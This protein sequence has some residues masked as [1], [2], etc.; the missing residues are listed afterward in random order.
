MYLSDIEILGFK[1]FAQK[2]N[3]K[4]TTGMTAIV[5]PNGCG[6]TNVVD[7][8]RWV[9]GEQKASTLRSDK[10]Y[11]VIFN[12][13][14]NRRPLGLAEVSLII[15]N[16]RKILPTEYSHVKIT[17]RLFRSSESQYLLNGVECRLRDINDLFM[18]TGMGPDAYSV[19]ELKMIETILSSKADERRRL[20][21]E[22]AGVTKYKARRKEAERKLEAVQGDL[23]RIQDIVIE[24][25]KTVRS[26]SR[27]AAKSKLAAE[28]KR[29]YDRIEKMILLLEYAALREQ[30]SPL[31]I[32]LAEQRTL[33][34]QL[35]NDVNEQ[36][37]ALGER[38]QAQNAVQSRFEDAENELAAA[39]TTVG[40]ASRELAVSNERRLALE[41]SQ[42]RLLRESEELAATLESTS[43]RLGEAQTEREIAAAELASTEGDYARSKALQDEAAAVVQSERNRTR[44]ANEAVRSAMSRIAAVRAEA[45]RT[46]ASINA[47]RRRIDET[48]RA[49]QQAEERLLGVQRE[50]DTAHARMVEFDHN[51]ATSGTELQNAQDLQARLQAAIE[52]SRAEESTLQSELSRKTASLEFLQGL[53]SGA[54]SAQFLMDTSAWQ[55][56]ERLTL[57]EALTLNTALQQGS[58]QEPSTEFRLALEAALGEAAGYFVVR[59]ADEAHAGM[60]ALSAAKKG[61]ATFICLDRV[62]AMPEPARLTDEINAG[63]NTNTNADDVLGWASELVRLTKDEYRADTRFGD[64]VRGVL[65][66]TVVTRSLA[67]AEALVS[68]GAAERA[69]TLAGELVTKQGVMRG[70]G[71]KPSDG[72]MIG[73]RDQIAALE[74]DTADLKASIEALREDIAT[75]NAALRGINLKQLADALRSAEGAKNKH[76]Q[77][78]AQLEYQAQSLQEG[79]ES[80]VRDIEKFTAE[81]RT[82]ETIEATEAN[83]ASGIGTGL[84]EIPALEAE[85]ASAENE[86]HA[87]EAALQAAETAFASASDDARER[88]LAVVHLRNDE[89]SLAAEIQRLERECETLE[90]R[91]VERKN[92]ASE[93]ADEAEAVQARYE[94]LSASFDALQST[95]T[96]ALNRRNAI[97]SEQSE[98]R[99]QSQVQN[100]ALRSV[101]REYERATTLFHETELQL[102]NLNNRADGFR[103]RAQEEFGFDLDNPPENILAEEPTTSS[104]ANST[105]DS[106]TPHFAANANKNDESNESNESTDGESFTIE[107]HPEGEPSTLFAA[108]NLPALKQESKV[109]KNKLQSIGTVNPLAYEEYERE[110]Q[111]LEFLETQFKDLQESERTLK[112]TIQE[113]NQTAQKQF[114]DVFERIRTNFIGIF[115]SLFNEGDE[116]DLQIEDGDPLEAPI[117]II[118]KPR[119]KRPASIEML[120]GGEKTLTAIALLFAIY[121]VKPSPFCILDEVDAPLDDANIDRYIRLIRRFSDTT[122]FIMITHNKRTMEAAETLYGVTMEEEGVSK[123]VSVK[124]ANFEDTPSDA[125]S[126]NSANSGSGGDFSSILG[127]KMT[128]PSSL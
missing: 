10:M 21:E 72:A 5:G 62:P 20:F 44:S 52:T 71:T 109:L 51:I 86:L 102:T 88:E 24:V 116:A 34:E 100:E 122:Q 57:A 119:G 23:T 25:Q 1:S 58:Q 104:M 121:L 66:S 90:R 75:N 46:I 113:I 37:Y 45:E 65:G 49:Q 35:E 120:S 14:K 91:I 31:Q 28:I 42:E 29:K 97:A 82:I 50:T 60:Q 22:A 78:L 98:L 103:T 64:I 9:L 56:S 4:F 93:A 110:S 126:R 114:Y 117:K 15:E 17:R 108:E 76:E 16:N 115:T 12:G 3:V 125:A 92:E 107:F 69:V 27:Q 47:L 61:K 99:K 19:I 124:F 13:T 70:G 112:S 73:K 26:L 74:R 53:V 128:S 101:R 38:E 6:K 96:E 7:A 18:D 83:A 43:V 79:V 36:E 80:R 33:R 81:I 41:R 32:S 2:T 8:L 87:A 11:D 123:I 94:E 30:L 40:N 118:A 67:S 77:T 39:N 59:S 48:E 85:K 106:S 95:A 89:R 111:R 63:A 68:S 54:E 84:A 127:P 105:A 55:P